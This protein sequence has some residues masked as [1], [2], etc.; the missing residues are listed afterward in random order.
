MRFQSLKLGIIFFGM[1]VPRFICYVT[2]PLQ[3]EMV[4]EQR[5]IQT[6][7]NCNNEK[8]LQE[9]F[10]NIRNSNLQNTMTLLRCFGGDAQLSGSFPSDVP[11]MPALT[12]IILGDHP[13]L[14]GTL[15]DSFFD[16]VNLEQL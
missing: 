11:P 9:V 2:F 5:E 16:L 8:S 14:T 13:K 1:R 4:L 6:R 3:D 15:P 7:F 10:D 12:N